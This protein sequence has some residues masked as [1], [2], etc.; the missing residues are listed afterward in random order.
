MTNPNGR[1][2]SKFET[3]LVIYARDHGHPHA[4]RL[5]KAG[6]NDIGDLTLGD[7]IP[8]TLEAKAEK[9]RDVPG[10][11]REARR[12]A[13]NAGHLRYAAIHKY[14]NHSIAESIVSIPF[15]LFLELLLEEK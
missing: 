14:R 6:R 11:L 12:E 5:V 13:E 4:R 15:W 7:T 8:W 9:V 1:T 2:G 3:D 10:A